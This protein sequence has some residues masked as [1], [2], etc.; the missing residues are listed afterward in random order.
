VEAREKAAAESKARSDEE[1]ARAATST[2]AAAR[3]GRGR[4]HP[5]HDGAPKKVLVAK[6][7]EEPKPVAKPAAGADAKGTLHK[8][9]AGT[10]VA[11]RPGAPAA[12][13]PPLARK[14]SRPSCR[15]AGLAIRPR[16]KK[17]RP[18]ATAAAVWA[19]TT[20]VV[21]RVAAVGDRDRVTITTSSPH[22][23]RRAS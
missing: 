17:S 23:S 14:S 1:A 6:K 18:V 21:A 19:A 2:H 15:P 10:G 20:G 7:P 22:R 8:P 16:R 5:R 3:P 11:A 9:A 13:V 4:S 12:Q